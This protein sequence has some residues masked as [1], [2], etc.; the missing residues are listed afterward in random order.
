MLNN[1]RWVF[2]GVLLLECVVC[3][4]IGFFFYHQYRDGKERERASYIAK[5]G[6]T[7]FQ[8]APTEDLPAFYE[9][10]P[11]AINLETPSWLG[12][13][14]K[15]TYNQDGLNERFEYAVE[16]PPN[17]LRIIALGDSF[18]HGDKVPTPQNWTELLED[19]LN[20]P[21]VD[22]CGKEKVEVLNLGVSGYDVRYI[23]HRYR[24]T[25]AKYQPDI[26]I[27]FESGSGFDRFNDLTLTRID[28]CKRRGMTPTLSESEKEKLY[29]TCWNT[30]SAEVA[31][32]Y[33]PEQ[34][35]ALINAGFQ[36][37]FTAAPTT[38]VL[39]ISYLEPAEEQI[40][41]LREQYLSGHANAQFL[42]I[43]PFLTPETMLRDGHPS[44][45]GH[46]VMEQVIREELLQQQSKICPAK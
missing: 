22:F 8:A 35:R 6:D 5:L 43:M 39:I 4:A 20:Q 7:V 21:A 2:I 30:V 19:S 36:E 12:Y 9:P 18:T 45:E 10:K 32:E 3:A 33:T 23:A 24:K 26:I 15:Q 42:P 40:K 1:R 41:A 44:I 17:T 28:E 27:W 38:P 37:F 13:Q 11:N 46:R 14:N 34:F 16:K 29:L 25:G 31:R